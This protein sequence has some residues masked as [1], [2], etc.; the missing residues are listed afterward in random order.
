MPIALMSAT[1]SATV[2]KNADEPISSIIA[3]SWSRR[4]STSGVGSTS[5]ASIPRRHRPASTDEAVRPSGTGKSGKCIRF[6]PR[7][8]VHVSAIRRVAS[9]RSGRSWNSARIA[10]AGFNQPSAFCRVT[11][12]CAIGT[13]F[14]MHSSASARNASSGTR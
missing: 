6:S 1:M 10:P 7:S 9:Q 13:I 11:W 5:R 12:F 3:S 14:R 2:R 4:A 8:N